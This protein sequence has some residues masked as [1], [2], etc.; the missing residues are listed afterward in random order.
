MRLARLA[1]LLLA[2]AA[3]TFSTGGVRPGDGAVD[4]DDGADADPATPPDAPRGPDAPPPIDARPPGVAP[5]G[6][7][8][9]DDDCA[10]VPGYVHICYRGVCM[11]RASSECGYSGS[12]SECADGS[13]CWF[14]NRGAGPLCWPDCDTHAC[15]GYCDGDG[16]CVPGSTNGCDLACGTSC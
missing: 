13:R 11:H 16:S 8:T 10:P 6:A 4:A 15:D 14:S 1:C 3:C 12:S 2:S 5:G 7:C 9:C